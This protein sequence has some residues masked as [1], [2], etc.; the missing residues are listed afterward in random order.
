M[1]I[2]YVDDGLIFSSDETIINIV[3][4]ELKNCFEITIGNANYFVGL[5]IHHD[6]EEGTMFLSQENYTRQIIRKFGQD[7]AHPVSVPMDVNSFSNIND[8][9]SETGDQLIP[10][11][12]AVGSL[13]FLAVVSRPDIAQAVG[14]VS[15]YLNN[16]ST[17]HWNMVKKIIRYLKGT[18]NY[19]ILYKNDKGILE[20]F[21][22]AD[23]AS[24]K[25]TRRST[26]GYVFKLN[27][28]PITWCSKL[29]PTVSL[30]T[31]ESEFIAA[32]QA[33]K[34]AI[35]LRKF[36]SDIQEDLHGP[37]QLMIDNQSAIKLIKNPEFHQRTKHIDIKFKFIREHYDCG[38]IEPNYINTKDQ[39]ADI[40]TKPLP[41][42]QFQRLRS[43]LGVTSL[44]TQNE[45]TTLRNKRW[46]YKK[47]IFV[48]QEQKIL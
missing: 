22:D 45:E 32:A 31:T 44:N 11:R 16:Y 15:R 17:V 18:V 39:E 41:K 9:S 35:W 29:Q 13:M 12:Q 40:F 26:T 8:E 21:S 48:P 1:L 5:E 4:E 7:D 33:T 2:I 20:G 43:K 34:E 36:M 14:V 38:D 46:E 25:E 19:G 47:N 10:Y 23:F 42:V 30:S 28:G 27:G 37:T 24:D 3:L 6:I